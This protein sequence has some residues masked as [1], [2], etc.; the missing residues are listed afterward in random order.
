MA[1]PRELY[2]QLRHL[3]KDPQP[4]KGDGRI[5]SFCPVHNDGS[6]NGRRSLSLHPKFGLVC[7]AGC[8]FVAILKALG[9][10]PG[11]FRQ[12]EPD[13]QQ[14]RDGPAKIYAYTD[15]RGG[16]VAEKG[17]WEDGDGGKSFKLRKAGGQW[18]EG[19]QDLKVEDLPLYRADAIVKLSFDT[20]IYFC[21]GEK[22]ADACVRQNLEA[23]TLAGGAGGKSFGTALELLRGRQVALWPDNDAPGRLHMVRV[24]AALRELDTTT[25][26]VTPPR[27]MPEKADAYDFFAMEGATVDELVS[28]LLKDII[29]EYLA[30][31]DVRVTVP[32]VGVTWVFDFTALLA[33]RHT[34]ECELAVTRVG[35]VAGHPYVQRI[36]LK[37][38]TA[39]VD[40]RRTLTDLHGK[41]H[42]WVQIVS[43]AIIGCIHAFDEHDVSID[44]AEIPDGDPDIFLVAPYL[45]FNQ[46]T[47]LFGDGSAG[48]TYWA[49]LLAIHMIYEIP[50]AGREMP[51]AR[52]LFVDYEDTP[53]NFKRRV[54]RVCAGMGVPVP[55]GDL[56]YWGAAGQSLFDMAPA[57]HKKCVEENINLV[58]IDSVGAATGGSPLE[59]ELALR[60]FAGLARIG[61]TTLSIAHITK[62]SGE[63]KGDTEKPFGSVYWH[64][65]ARR[66]WYI[67][68][69]QDDDA[70]VIDITLF[71]RKVNDGPRVKPISFQVVF[72][73]LNGPVTID[74]MR[75]ID[76][77]E[78]QR[79]RPLSD[80]VWDILLQPMTAQQ[81]ADVIDAKVDSVEKALAKKPKFFIGQILPGTP[82]TGGRV[83][84]TWARI[85]LSL[86]DTQP[87]KS[88]QDA[89]P[90]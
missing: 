28:G 38:H 83:P 59:V 69:A 85:A 16:L 84:K 31:E 1:E 61:V 41:D 64:N 26:F 42:P 22:A 32:A 72:D 36:N 35:D 51:K 90:F 86:G 81:I 17:R 25:W 11:D 19:L 48:K 9:V 60:Y 33:G 43:D 24:A 76:I 88:S 13:P 66:T 21:E 45:P 75:T 14:I 4:P 77:P 58:I 5:W 62:A 67:D 12:M 52:I 3:L 29:I 57:I 54:G 78:H 37:S 2:E 87:A 55:R 7:F 6:K 63:A 10:E 73:G 47:I 18:K 30:L 49:L 82:P 56:R 65:T 79:R 23:T 27:Q 15:E 39:V 46:A 80:Q 40:L 20:I 34:L 70:D 74:S 71:N 44:V 50:L 68:R 89:L 53:T 8:D